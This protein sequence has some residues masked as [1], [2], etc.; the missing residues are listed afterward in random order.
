M[1]SCRRRRRA[2]HAPGSPLE[3]HLAADQPST[4]TLLGELLKLLEERRSEEARFAAAPARQLPSVVLFLDEAVSPE[5]SQIGPVLTDG[6]AHGIYVLW[7]GNDARSLPG[8]CRAVIELDPEVASLTLTETRSGDTV[9]NVIEGQKFEALN[10][11]PHFQ[12][13][14][15]VSFQ[16]HCETQAEIDHFWSKLTEGGK[17]QPCGWVKDRFG[18]SWQ[19]IPNALPQ[20]LM[21]ENSEKAQR[22]MKSML[23]M[24]KIDLDALKRAQAA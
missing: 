4:R 17:E 20:M 1:S 18:L 10:G 2:P 12:F 7:L 14:E 22:V 11:G 24:R 21:D 3:T 13:N 16:I 6:A 15:A 5:R 8:E 19:V 23:Q 9:E